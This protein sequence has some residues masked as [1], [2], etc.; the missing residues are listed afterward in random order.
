MALS[1]FLYKNDA[2]I[3]SLYAQVFGGKI[4]QFH[5]NNSDSVK[6]GKNLTVKGK[7]GIPSVA[8]IDGGG[9][10]NTAETTT[11]S[12]KRIISPHD[13]ATIFAIYEDEMILDDAPLSDEE[14]VLLM[15]RHLANLAKQGNNLLSTGLKQ[16]SAMQIIAIM[17]N[18]Q[19]DP[20][21]DD[22]GIS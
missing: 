15:H 9:N 6:I 4:D 7:V 19:A 1:S 18:V 14:D 2:L 20:F 10:V 17:Q 3:T 5:E 12:T 13:T 21:V 22:N 16:L 8:N 11:T